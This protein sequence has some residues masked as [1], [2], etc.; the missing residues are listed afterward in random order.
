MHIR[1]LAHYATSG[2]API[3]RGFDKWWVFL[4]K[5]GA[6]AGAVWFIAGLLIAGTLISG[7]FLRRQSVNAIAGESRS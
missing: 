4:S 3:G 7:W 2:A 5:A 1:L 6:S